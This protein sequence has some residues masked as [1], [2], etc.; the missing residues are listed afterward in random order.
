MELWNQQLV[1]TIQDALSLNH[2]QKGVVLSNLLLQKHPI[3]F[4]KK[5]LNDNVIA[6]SRKKRDPPTIELIAW[7]LT[8]GRLKTTSFFVESRPIDNR[9]G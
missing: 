4:M 3:L 5:K 9:S 6:F 8:N 2:D 7:F 1:Q